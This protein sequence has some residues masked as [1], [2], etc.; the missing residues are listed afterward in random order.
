MSISKIARHIALGVSLSFAG[1]ASAA[2][3][4]N[5]SYDPTRELYADYNGAFAKHWK[6]KTEKTSPSSSRTADRANR[7]ARSSTASKPMS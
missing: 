2:E 1:P 3:L 4:L 7:P 6:E 5:V